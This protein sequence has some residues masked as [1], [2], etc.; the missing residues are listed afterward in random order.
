MNIKDLKSKSRKISTPVSLLQLQKEQ[1]DRI[2]SGQ[3]ETFEKE[4]IERSQNHK[5]PFFHKHSSKL[6]I[7]TPHKSESPQTLPPNVGSLPSYHGS[8]PKKQTH[9]RFSLQQHLKIQLNTSPSLIKQS[10][11]LSLSHIIPHTS[12]PAQS[13]SFPAHPLYHQ[14]PTATSETPQQPLNLE[15]SF[16]TCHSDISMFNGLVVPVA[17]WGR[18]PISHSVTSILMTTDQKY[19]VTGCDDGHI[20]VWQHSDGSVVRANYE[21]EIIIILKSYFQ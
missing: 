1:D 12:P 15:A 11:R 5:K 8:P 21:K 20:C 7:F 13:F 17:V 4:S 19:I 9:K 6:Q 10:H 18:K 2:Q 16:D 14:N 3:Y